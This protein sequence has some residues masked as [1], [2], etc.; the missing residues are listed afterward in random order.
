V[1]YR[2]KMQPVVTAADG[3]ARFAENRIVRK[4]L[5]FAQERGYGLNEI[6]MDTAEGKFDPAEVEQLMQL[7]GYSV[8][9]FC[10]LSTSTAY[11]KRTAWA[12]AQKLISEEDPTSA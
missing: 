5:T 11:S 6:A 7:L 12:K 2:F 10:D 4:L 1:T 8:S 3:C 9:G